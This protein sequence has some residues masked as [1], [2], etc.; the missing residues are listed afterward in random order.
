MSNDSNW[1][2]KFKVLPPVQC[3]IGILLFFFKKNDYI[4]FAVNL[5][6]Y[7]YSN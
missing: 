1:S 3:I 6:L 7:I 5:F 4:L 2:H